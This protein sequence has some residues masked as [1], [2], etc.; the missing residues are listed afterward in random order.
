MRY[1][2]H[3]HTFPRG[4]AIRLNQGNHMA[5]FRKQFKR[6]NFDFDPPLEQVADVVF[7]VDVAEY[8][9]D[10]YHLF[11]A[12]AG[13]ACSKQNP[14]W[15]NYDA[16]IEGY[17]GWSS[18]LSGDGGI[19]KVEH[20]GLDF[21]LGIP[22]EGLPRIAEIFQMKNRDPNSQPWTDKWRVSGFYK[23][24]VPT[25]YED[26]QM[27]AQMEHVN[28]MLDKIKQKELA[29]MTASQRRVAEQECRVVQCHREE[30]EFVSGSGV[31]G[32]IRRIED[33][34]ITG[35]V[36]W[37]DRTIARRRRDYRILDDGYPTKIWMYWLAE[38]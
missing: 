5:V 29:N 21:D 14:H 34:V 24:Y 33:I 1:L 31:A 22:G 15:S 36:G 4:C 28:D 25:V 37:E 9:D 18:I 19:T 8:T 23:T 2:A 20:I 7:E 11:E 6:M 26:P 27:M 17:S 13:E 38:K 10:N 35:L 12:A 32:C 3:N 16:P 30:A